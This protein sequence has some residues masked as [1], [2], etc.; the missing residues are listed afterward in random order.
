MR[1][2]LSAVKNFT[3]SLCHNQ[4]IGHFLTP[5]DLLVPLPNH[6]PLSPSL[7]LLL[8]NVLAFLPCDF[9]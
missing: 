6:F 5:T 3:K 2:F 9:K 4:D 1:R 7:D 8:I